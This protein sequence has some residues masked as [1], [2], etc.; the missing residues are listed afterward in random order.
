MDRKRN[1][2]TLKDVAA[3]AGLNTGTVSR[4]LNE[5]FENHTYREETIKRVREAAQKLNYKPNR[6]ARSLRTRRSGFIGLSIPFFFSREEERKPSTELLQR[7][8]S[9]ALSE[10]MAGL[11]LYAYPQNFDIITLQRDESREGPL[12]VQEIFPPVIDGLIYLNVTNRH[13][14]FYDLDLKK[15]PMVLLGENRNHP[16]MFS[17]DVDNYQIGYKLTRHLIESGA[18]RIAYFFMDSVE[19]QVARL[20]YHGYR[21]AL[22]EAGIAC[23]EAL[24]HQGRGDG[25]KEDEKI[26]RSLL[27]KN[28]DV[29]GV[30]FM[31]S[32]LHQIIR[33]VLQEQDKK[34]P[35]DV[36][37]AGCSTSEYLEMEQNDLSCINIPAGMM[38]YEAANLLIQQI[39]GDPPSTVRHI[40]PVELVVRGSSQGLRKKKK[41][42]KLTR[43]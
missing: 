6:F 9:P 26:V 10:M 24:V 31:T 39:E 41:S 43:A 36:L 35:Q 27:S 14:E 2:A 17:C 25:N 20:R 23:D 40:L 21:D 34:V 15:Y 1:T 12:N 16:E 33:R 13:Q 28:A 32:G 18:S 5:S 4:I 7:Y 11:S 3:A 29:D 19:M 42:R 8:A 37:L 30:L 38:A 22:G